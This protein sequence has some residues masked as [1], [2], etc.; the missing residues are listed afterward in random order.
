MSKILSGSALIISAVILL[1]FSVMSACSSSIIIIDER[2]FYIEDNILITGIV[3]ISI[4]ILTSVIYKNKN[5]LTIVSEWLI[6]RFSLIKNISIIVGIVDSIVFVFITQ[7]VPTDDQ[8]MLI[9]AVEQMKSNNYSVWE[10]GNYFSMWPHQNFL[11]LILLLL[12]YIFPKYYVLVFQLLNC[13][14]VGGIYYYTDKTIEKYNF[15]KITRILVQLC[16]LL[17]FPIR[18]YVTFVY[19][20]LLG[21]FFSVYAIYKWTDFNE[22][23]RVSDAI[24]V[25]ICFSLAILIKSN[26]LIFMIGTVICSIL[27]IIKEK[28]VRS[29]L[30]IFTIVLFYFVSSVIVDYSIVHM[31]GVQ[32]SHKMSSL[33]F[34][35]MGLHENPYRAPGWRDETH[36]EKYMAEI[37]GNGNENELAIED[38]KNS[39]NEF[40]RNDRDFLGFIARKQSSV[41]ANPTFQ[42]QWINSRN[43]Y[44]IHT[45]RIAEWLLSLRTI[46][47]LYPAMDIFIVIVYLGSLL[48]AVESLVKGDFDEL[49]VLYNI[50]FIG[51]VLF[52]TLW[53]AKAQYSLPYF[54]LLIP[55]SV[56]GFRRFAV[57]I[58]GVNIFKLDF[59]KIISKSGLIALVAALVFLTVIFKERGVISKLVNVSSDQNNYEKYKNYLLDNENTIDEGL[60]NIK[61]Y[62]GQDLVIKDKEAF[63]SLVEVRTSNE[64]P[65][66]DEA[67]CLSI[68]NTDGK[69]MLKIVEADSNT[70]SKKGFVAVDS[71]EGGMYTEVTCIPYCGFH[72]FE[73]S[74]ADGNNTE[75]YI[76]T[77]DNYALT[78]SEEG[79]IVLEAFEGKDNQKWLLEKKDM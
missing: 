51:G 74:A 50:I 58:S 34:A 56:C 35:A 52:H 49:A 13:L 18:M 66:E 73:I 71:L 32:K 48:Y 36:I 59:R 69:S 15:S 64:N 42:A 9:R 54:V 78:L 61:A 45:G 60:Y 22:E 39:I 23:H 30:I 79:T 21:L 37:T 26:Y 31:T 25:G 70:N 75:Y 5:K 76:K 11:V 44:K 10:N 77:I 65:A 62:D 12:S 29:L 1:W 8:G 40:R 20:T 4:I 14:A 38:I 57:R 46:I 19:G 67:M 33:S 53:E 2:T 27:R 7:M 55:Y 41:W 43:D 24:I 3:I 68:E 16:F 63:T 47:I 28:K 17:F 6:S 72:D